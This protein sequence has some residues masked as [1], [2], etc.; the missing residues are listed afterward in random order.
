MVSLAAMVTVSLSASGVNV[1]LEPW[2]NVTVSV[3]ESAETLVV[4]V[5]TLTPTVEKAFWLTSAPDAIPF[6]LVLSDK[7]I[8]PLADV[9][10]SE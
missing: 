10:A 9:V 1:T 7:L 6:N 5:P 2:I 8:K 4:V 3:L